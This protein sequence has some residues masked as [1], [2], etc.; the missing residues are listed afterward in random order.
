MEEVVPASSDGGPFVNTAFHQR[1]SNGM[2]PAIH[3]LLR[4][5]QNEKYTMLL[6]I[7]QKVALLL[8][9]QAC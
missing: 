9:L 8:T 7:K 5:L 4:M 3:I 2:L 6:D 1:G